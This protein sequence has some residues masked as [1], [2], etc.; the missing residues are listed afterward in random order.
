VKDVSHAHAD[1]ASHSFF[2]IERTLLRPLAAVQ[3]LYTQAGGV[4]GHVM[5]L[6]MF[7]M[8]PTAH[9]KIRQQSHETFWYTHQLYIVFLLAMYTH[10]TEC[11][12]RDSVEAYSPFDGKL[13]WTHCKGYEGWR[14]EMIV[15]AW[16]AG[17]WVWRAVQARRRTEI[18]RVIKHPYGMCGRVGAE[19]V[20]TQADTLCRGTGVANQQ[21]IF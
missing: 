14:W 5:L 20:G 16:F 6:C 1:T 3:I 15:G 21:T 4:T 19:V 11:F 12:V 8:I 9:A 10:A 13:F 7:L 2:N 17:E 18:V